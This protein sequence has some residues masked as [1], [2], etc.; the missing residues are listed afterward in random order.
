MFA[1]LL[2]CRGLSDV[3][4][5]SFFFFFLCAQTFLLRKCIHINVSHYGLGGTGIACQLVGLSAPIQNGPGACPASYLVGAGFFLGVNWSDHGIEHPSPTSHK[6]KERVL[7]YCYC[8]LSWAVLGW[9]SPFFIFVCHPKI[10]VLR[11]AF[12]CVKEC[13]M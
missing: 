5:V 7:L 13:V 9:T 10:W 12:W 1:L 2:H 8:G 6:V 11:L 3:Y 4:C